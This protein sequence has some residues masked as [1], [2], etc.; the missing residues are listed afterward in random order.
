M[1]FDDIIKFEN[2]SFNEENNIKKH[3]K[4]N[5]DNNYNNNNNNNDIIASET[6][7]LYNFP[8]YNNK[9]NLK[10]QCI[11]MIHTHINKFVQDSFYYRING[12]ETPDV[13]NF[14]NNIKIIDKCIE[15]AVLKYLNFECSNKKLL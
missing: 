5:S 3:I 1:N 14:L 6:E 2:K 4:S 8:I 15:L 7:K 11:T 9:V 12:K 13:M 10:S